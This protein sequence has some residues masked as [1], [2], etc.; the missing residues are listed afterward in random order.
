[1]VSN[2][3]FKIGDNVVYPSHGVG[4]I[5]DIEVQ[6]FGGLELQ[7]FVI[8]FEREKMSLRIPTAK[9]KKSGLR[10]LSNGDEVQ[11][12]LAVLKSKP[13][14]SKGMWSRRASEYEAKINSGELSLIAEVVRDL[15]KNVDDP[16]RSYSER[17]IY[18]SALSR[19]SSEYAVLNKIAHEVASSQIVEVIREKQSA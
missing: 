12:V 8:Y 4:T 10:A 6:A 19:L 14:T 7:F 3:E 16:D 9:A 1:M 17:M 18:E 13:K 11:K 5:Q 2:S 15:H